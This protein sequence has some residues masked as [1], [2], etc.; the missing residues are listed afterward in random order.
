MADWTFHCV[1]V[2]GVPDSQLVKFYVNT[3][4]GAEVDGAGFC[5]LF[6]QTGFPQIIRTETNLFIPDAVI[7]N[8]NLDRL[9]PLSEVPQTKVESSWR[10]PT[11]LTGG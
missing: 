9:Q 8:P 2:N 5:A 7:A 3:V 10:T 4:D 6:R 1:K 11:R